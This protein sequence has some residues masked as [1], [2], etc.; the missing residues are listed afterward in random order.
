[1]HELKFCPP[2]Y[3]YEQFV[4]LLIRRPC[5]NDSE[6][7]TGSCVAA[8]AAA[9]TF[10]ILK[11]ANEILRTFSALSSSLFRTRFTFPCDF[12]ENGCGERHTLRGGRKWNFALFCTFNV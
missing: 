2:S 9:S 8:A 7:V 6:A 11:G 5:G 12:S 10:E 1:M 3:K 4:H